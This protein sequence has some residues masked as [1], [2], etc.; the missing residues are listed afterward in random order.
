MDISTEDSY[1]AATITNVPRKPCHNCRRS[2]LR[3]DESLPTC[4]K[5]LRNGEECLGYQKFFSWVNGVASRGKMV[6]KSFDNAKRT[7]KIKETPA[8][9]NL[10]DE[11]F[12]ET[13]LTVAP[14]TPIIGQ[15]IMPL[16]RFMSDPLFQDLDQNSRFF[17]SYC[18][19]TCLV[20]FPRKADILCLELLLSSTTVDTHVCK[21]LVIYDKPYQNHYRDLLPFTREYKSLLHVILATSALHF[22]NALERHHTISTAELSSDLAVTEKS[23]GSINPLVASPQGVYHYALIAKQRALRLL[24]LELRDPTQTNIMVTLA[25]VLLFIDL[26]L[27]DSGKNNW[28]PHVEG[29]RML[30]EHL[31]SV[32][33]I[34]A[35]PTGFLMDSLISGCLV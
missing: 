25:C 3:C 6:G 13:S 23:S 32:Q 11:R 19:S 15:H 8:P 9:V 27:I 2:R 35:V 31:A 33:D 24:S 12:E 34:R 26:E 4:N 14:K 28:R 16:T 18:K 7:K 17:L 21:D 29:S 20:S 10:Q 1:T 22:S 30:M 5:C